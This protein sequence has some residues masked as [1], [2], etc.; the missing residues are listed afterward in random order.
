M[1]PQHVTSVGIDLENK[2]VI[3]VQKFRSAGRYAE[4]FLQVRNTI[5]RVAFRGGD[6]GEGLSDFLGEWW[7]AH[8]NRFVAALSS[9]AQQQFP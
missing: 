8:A 9:G 6:R 4:E 2:G 7:V 1:R 3:D 5:D